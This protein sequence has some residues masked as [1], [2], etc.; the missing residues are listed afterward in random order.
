MPNS[1]TFKSFIIKLV[2]TSQSLST[3][4]STYSFY[5]DI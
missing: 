5:L 4:K 1:H 3:Q 2:N